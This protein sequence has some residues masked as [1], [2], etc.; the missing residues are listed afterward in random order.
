LPALEFD[1]LENPDLD[2]EHLAVLG[3][4]E[5]GADQEEAGLSGRQ[6]SRRLGAVLG[7]LVLVILFAFAV[8]RLWPRTGRR[9]ISW[10]ARKRR[11]K[12]EAEVTYFRRFERA[13]TRGDARAAVNLLLSW[14]DRVQ[15]EAESPTIAQFISR[16]GDADLEAQ[17]SELERLLFSAQAERPPW[18]GHL[19]REAMKSA[20]KK[21]LRGEVSLEKQRADRLVLNPR[22]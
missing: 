9:L 16:H 15:E 21:M 22:G 7:L 17:V 20:R 2:P 14:I 1:V 12:A 5:L 6:S 19:L 4:E 13:C 8:Y 3:E 11:E 10:L 18:N